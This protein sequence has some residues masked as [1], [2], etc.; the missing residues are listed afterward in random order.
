MHW[1]STACICIQQRKYLGL[2]PSRAV[3]QWSDAS[4]TFQL[5]LE[6]QRP[7]PLAVKRAG[8]PYYTSQDMVVAKVNSIV[9]GALGR[10][11]SLPQKPFA[12]TKVL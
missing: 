10:V 5:L 11:L 12:A 2:A 6:M 1:Q 7:F 3:Q 8:I 4:P 9:Q